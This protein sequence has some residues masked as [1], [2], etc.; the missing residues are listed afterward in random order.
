MGAVEDL[1]H[2]TGW[3]L[4]VDAPEEVMAGFQWSGDFESGYVAALRVDS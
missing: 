2:A 4:G 1:N 3:N